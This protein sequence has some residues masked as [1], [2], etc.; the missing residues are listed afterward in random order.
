MLNTFWHFRM[1]YMQRENL[2]DIWLHFCISGTQKE[3]QDARNLGRK[4]WY[5]R[6][7]CP[8][9]LSP[10]P[11]ARS[12]LQIPQGHRDYSTWLWSLGMQLAN[13]LTEKPIYQDIYFGTGWSTRNQICSSTLN[14]QKKL[15]KIQTTTVSRHPV[16]SIMRLAPESGESWVRP[17]HCLQTFR[18]T[19]Q[20]AQ[21]LPWTDPET[22]AVRVR[23]AEPPAQGAAEAHFS[24]FSSTLMRAGQ[25]KLRKDHPT[26]NHPGSPT[27]PFGSSTRA[28][29]ESRQT[30]CGSQCLK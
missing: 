29:E 6:N 14:H 13:H 1:S 3:Y 12:Y 20:G 23:G 4:R 22:Q 26:G 18:R 15:G 8:Q 16:L 7:I 11:S 21:P 27:K 24:G 30:L 25:R 9:T 5:P 10:C 28:R 17:A 19:A 2:T